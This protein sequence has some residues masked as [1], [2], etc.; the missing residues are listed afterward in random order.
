MIEDAVQG[1][2]VEVD[3]LD[4]AG[5]LDLVRGAEIQARTAERTRLRAA[6][7]WV[8]LNPATG[9]SGVEAWGN[10]GALDCE[11][12]IGGPGTP[13]LAAFG[14]EPFGAAQGISKI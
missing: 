10:A 1:D 2:V 14:A 7:L 5:V 4:A 13:S 9:S 11:V 3:D 12:P 8:Y 6:N